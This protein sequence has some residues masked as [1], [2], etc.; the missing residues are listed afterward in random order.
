MGLF[1]FLYLVQLRDTYTN[2][3]VFKFIAVILWNWAK[4]IF[5]NITFAVP[6]TKI[7]LSLILWM[8][9][10]RVYSILTCRAGGFSHSHDHQRGTAGCC[11][12]RRTVRSWTPPN[13]WSVPCSCAR[14]WCPVS[15]H[16]RQTDM[17]MCCT[18]HHSVGYQTW[19]GSCS[20]CTS[21]TLAPSLSQQLI[22]MVESKQFYSIKIM[23]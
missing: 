1:L 20:A 10:S 13:S 23:N 8:S 3:I 18:P 12:L 5:K 19:Q 14:D 22:S 7:P 11:K 9:M 2:S 21:L 4:N 6:R 15:S 17:Q 16:C